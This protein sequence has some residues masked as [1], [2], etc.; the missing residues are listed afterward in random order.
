MVLCQLLS[1]PACVPLRCARRGGVHWSLRALSPRCLAPSLR[2]SLTG[3]L[4]GPDS[5]RPPGRDL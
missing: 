4:E 5:G 2:G 3:G 1:G